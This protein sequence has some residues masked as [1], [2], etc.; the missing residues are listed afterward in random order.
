MAFDNVVALPKRSPSTESILVPTDGSALSLAAALN[1][2]AFAK[3]LDA[4]VVAFQAVPAY[5][6]PVYV[7]G[8]PFE[9]PSEAEYEDQCRAIAE[10]YLALIS[11][12]ATERGVAVA[13]RI[14]FNA[15]PA[16][17][18]VDAAKRESCSMIFM[19]SHGRGGLSR[20]FLGSVAHKTLTL[21][22]LPVMVD[23]PTLEEVAHAEALMRHSAIEP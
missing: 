8:I 17:S 19:G 14:E 9:Y 6:Y 3:R 18:I 7:G 15:G 10:R 22:P 20:V 23:R 12:A 13:T 4:R 11:D 2:V 16:Q 1:A 21:S 5:Q